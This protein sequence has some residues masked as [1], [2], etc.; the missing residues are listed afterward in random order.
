MNKFYEAI[1][2]IVDDKTYEFD[3]YDIYKYGLDQYDNCYTLYKKYNRK[4][5]FFD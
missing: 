2:K 1:R 4:D 5:Q 3:V